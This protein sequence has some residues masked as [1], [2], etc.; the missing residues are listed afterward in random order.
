MT[1][2]QAL[3][4][5]I[6]QGL[7]EFLPVSSTA[8]LLIAQKLLGIQAGD[9]SFAF[10]VLVQLGTLLSLIVYFWR[11][12]WHIARAMLTGLWQRQPFGDAQ[13]RLGWYL[14]LGTVPAVLAGV[15]FKPLVEWLFRDFALEA[16]IRLSMTV[17]LLLA[18]ER[19]GKRKRPLGELNWKDALWV[20]CAQALAVFPGASRSGATIAGGMTRHFDRPS[21]ARFAFLLSVPVMVG[22]G[23][24][25]AL[26]LLASGHVSA[27]VW[28]PVLVGF[29]AA[30]IVGF[31]AIHWLLKFLGQRSLNVFAAYCGVLA[32]ITLLLRMI[33]TV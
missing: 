30:A 11:E 4:L 25:E 22:A 5:G 19:L 21:A 6:V 8:H 29:A 3:I 13:A 26:D 15:V 33:S 24:Y 27:S 16:V 28:L 31:F 9:V 14:V 17:A 23:G 32:L 1:L 12:L 18:A 20:G 10:T 7:T 2:L